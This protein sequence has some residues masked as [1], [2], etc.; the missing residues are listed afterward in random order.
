MVGYCTS[1]FKKAVCISCRPCVDVHKGGGE[2]GPCGRMWT[3][4]RR[5]QKRDFFVDIINGWPLTVR[6]WYL[7]CSIPFSM[8]RLAERLWRVSLEEELHKSL[9]IIL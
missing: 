7:L 8:S 9:I 2:S 5:G 6:T 4:G 1:H 3:R